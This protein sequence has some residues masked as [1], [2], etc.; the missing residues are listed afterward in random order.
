L[1]VQAYNTAKSSETERAKQYSAPIINALCNGLL[2]KCKKQ[3]G[4]DSI[5]PT[6][7]QLIEEEFAPYKKISLPDAASELSPLSL[8]L[9]E[10]FVNDEF[11]KFVNLASHLREQCENNEN[12][13]LQIDVH[14]SSNAEKAGAA[15]LLENI[16]DLEAQRATLEAQLTKCDEELH[17]QAVIQESTENKRNKVHL[18]IAEMADVNDDNA[19]ILQYATM[20][21]EVMNEFIKRLQRQKVAHLEDNITHCFKYL[22]QKEAIITSIHIDPITL[23]ITLKDYK[24]GT[25][26]KEQ[27]SAGEKQMFA[28]SILWGL[29]LSSGYKLP[30]IIDTPMARLDSAHRSNFINK[31]LPNAS[32]QVIVLSTDEEVYGRYLDE[33]R[34]YVNAYYTLVYD[35]EEKCSSIVPGYFG[36]AENDL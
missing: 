10:K 9:I 23:D 14:L 8:A 16:K 27:L 24:G 21:I 28:I 34:P 33:V 15:Q 1:V 26:L 32:S 29:A 18:K 22:A 7:C 35:E 5:Y 11:I 13:L 25:L 20:S 31:Y 4:K 12:M 2:E 3:Y 36:G 19:R 30:V 6:L 17:S